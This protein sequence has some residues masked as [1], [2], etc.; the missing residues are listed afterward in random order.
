M[1]SRDEYQQRCARLSAAMEPHSVAIIPANQEVIRSG[2]SHYRFRQN[3]HFYYLTGFEEP[4]AVLIV[5]SD[6]DKGN[7]LFNRRK[8]PEREIWD[9]PR[10]GQEQAP[11]KLGVERAFPIEDFAKESLEFLQGCDNIYYAMGM[12][13]E[14]EA[15]IQQVMTKLKGLI[16]KGIKAPSRFVDLEPLLSELRLI[17]SPAEQ[18]V[19]RKAAHISAHAHIRAMQRCRHLDNEYQLE[20]EL[21]Y[22]FSKHGCRSVAYNPIV[23]SGANACVLHYEANNQALQSG[24]LVLID[25][26]GEYANYAADITR[27]F[28]VTGTFSDA[29][30]QIY[31]LV[32]QSQQAGIACIAP[33][34]AWNVIQDTI[35]HVLCEGLCGLGILSGSVEENIEAANYRAF[36]MHNSGHWLGIDVHDCGAYK[37]DGNWRPLEAGMVLTVEPGLYFSPNDS[38]IDACWRGIGVRIEDDILVTPN[39]YENLTAAVPVAIDEIEA[40]MRDEQEL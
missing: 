35:V 7:L 8:D 3:A 4:E 2:D 19:M 20:A 22:G 9:G 37:K 13:P 11:L 33:G 31:Q 21:L 36:Y 23:G 28:P 26:G 15:R 39:G 6:K 17:K 29:Q 40:L 38:S 1:I 5:F 27:T 16:R 18:A 34:V 24:D 14:W 10:L 25:A 32:L 30:R 12:F